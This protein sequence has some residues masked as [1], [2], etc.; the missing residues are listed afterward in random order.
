MF[1]VRN[2][3]TCVSYSS[4]FPFVYK[5][6]LNQCLSFLLSCFAVADIRT[7]FPC[8]IKPENALR[9]TAHE[10]LKKENFLPFLY[11]YGFGKESILK[12]T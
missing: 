7:Q 5:V 6:V 2:K 3:L 9:F 10:K 11:T 12:V 1:V 4:V 8:D